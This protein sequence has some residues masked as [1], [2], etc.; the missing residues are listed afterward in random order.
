ME[1]S[2]SEIIDEFKFAQPKTT[3]P[4]VEFFNEFIKNNDLRL[5]H[6]S[7]RADTHNGVFDRQ[8]LIQEGRLA[9]LLALK[10]FDQTKGEFKPYAHASVKSRL[11][12]YSDQNSF[13]VRLPAH[14]APYM[15][16]YHRAK[17]S[18]TQELGRIP[19]DEEVVAF[20]PL[21]IRSQDT[22]WANSVS[23]STEHEDFYE[24]AN[25]LAENSAIEEDVVEKTA[26]RFAINT[27]LSESDLTKK[28]KEVIHLRYRFDKPAIKGQSDLLGYPEI[29]RKLDLTTQRVHQIG[30]K[31]LLKLKHYFATK[32]NELEG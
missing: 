13:P 14:V 16:V 9:V 12:R 8:D 22:I 6:L 10:N 29:G 32:K 3:G 31:A 2:S 4:T 20:Y 25:T 15:R 5:K 18:I 28:E 23:V 19:S 26:A 27:A 30:E 11:Y 1:R 17:W 24:E 7:W 21:P